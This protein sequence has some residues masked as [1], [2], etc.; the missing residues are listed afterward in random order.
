M[1]SNQPLSK[2]KKI[3]NFILCALFIIFA[4]LQLNDPDGILWFSI[5]FI[6]AITCLYNSFK[7]ISRPFL[8]LILIALLAYAAF[9]FSLFIDYLKT[10]DKEEI[11]GEMV[12][13]KPYLEGTREFI[14]LLIAALGI[15]YQIKIRKRQ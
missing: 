11:F 12:Y 1:K 8:I 15:M 3:I 6:V 4:L 14:G 10:E 7:P 5:Y 13:D 9:H 2:Q